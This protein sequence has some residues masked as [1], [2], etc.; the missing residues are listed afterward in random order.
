[1]ISEEEESFLE[2]DSTKILSLF[3]KRNIENVII[4]QQ[5]Y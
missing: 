3:R 5:K 2:D 1:M 4:S